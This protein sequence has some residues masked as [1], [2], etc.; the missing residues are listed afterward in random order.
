MERDLFQVSSQ[1]AVPKYQQLINSILQAIE[2]RELV[3]GDQLPS[4]N[5]L[6][7]KYAVSQDTVLAAY[8]ELKARGIISSQVGKG[9]YI[10][11]TRPNQKKKIFVLF[12]RLTSYKE[13]LYQSFRDEIGADVSVEIFFHHFNETVFKRLVEDANG[14]YTSFVIMPILKPSCIEALARLPKKQVYILD[15]GGGTLGKEYASVCQDFRTD[16]NEGLTKG[17]P[18]LRKYTELRLVTS[19]HRTHFKDIMHSFIE[20]CKHNSIEGEV[21][22]DLKGE[23]V[24]RGQA[25]IVINDQV[26]VELVKRVR[27]TGL[28][29]GKDV[30]IISYNDTPLKEVVAE[31]IT[32][33]ST[34]FAEMGK[35]VA[36]LIKTRT[37][38]HLLNAS[39]LIIRNSL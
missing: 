18:L 37:K 15:Q 16:L 5:S 36:K 30:G 1:T 3:K 10:A 17:I 35:T 25:Y 6:K 34:D 33:I 14:Q 26:L 23:V 7:K 38:Q 24:K 32:V 20:F 22:Q 39:E 27:E 2:H 28:T 31:G 29:L 9:Y 12:D 4:I 8:K 13:V 21:I 11:S 19:D